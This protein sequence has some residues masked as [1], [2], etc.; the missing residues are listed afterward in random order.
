MA[1]VVFQKTAEKRRA[2]TVF[3]VSLAPG[4]PERAKVIQ[5]KIGVVIDLRYDGR[6]A[7]HYTTF[8]LR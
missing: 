8:P 6:G 7:R 1:I 3:V 2:V 5:H 4:A